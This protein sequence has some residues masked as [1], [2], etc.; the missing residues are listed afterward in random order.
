MFDALYLSPHF[1]DAVLSCGAQ[2]YDRSQRGERVAVVTVCAASAPSEL[3]P[4]AAALH[5]RWKEAGDFDRAAEDREALALLG[6][7]PIHLPFHDC[8]YRRAP[9]GEWLYTSEAA[10]FGPV[11]PHETAL[12]DRLVEAFERVGSRPGAAVLIPRAIG[13]HVDHQLVRTA[14]ETC[15]RAQGRPFQYYADFPY[16]EAISGGRV[17]RVTEAGRRQKTRAIRAYQSQLSTFWPDDRTLDT[18][19]GQWEERTF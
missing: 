19:V 13:N 2:I 10:I 8:I 15:C 1:D 4:F 3:S 16:A 7:T 6:A 17:V 12:V 14:G 9:S 18:K 11:S 5:A